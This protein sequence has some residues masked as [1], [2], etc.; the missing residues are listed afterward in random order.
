MNVYQ[1]QKGDQERQVNWK[2]LSEAEVKELSVWVA[3][4]LNDFNH[5]QLGYQVKHVV[6]DLSLRYA[7]DVADRYY[8]KI[9][10]KDSPHDSVALE[11]AA[12]AI[13]GVSAVAESLAVG[14]LPNNDGTISMDEL[15]KAIYEAMVMMLFD[16]KPS[17][18][19][20][21]NH[22]TL[23]FAERVK[24][25]EFRIGVAV[26]RFGL[27][28]LESFMP[29]QGNL[30]EQFVTSNP[31]IDNLQ[32]EIAKVKQQ[33]AENDQLVKDLKQQQKVAQQASDTV[34]QALKDKQNEFI[35]A[36]ENVAQQQEKLAKL[37]NTLAT[38]N[39]SLE[40]K[41]AAV[42]SAN[43]EVER[44]NQEVSEK[45]KVLAEIK[46][47]EGQLKAQRADIERNFD[48]A[49]KTLEVK[50]NAVDEAKGHL[51]QHHA[52]LTKRQSAVQDAKGQLAQAEDNL[53]HS[54]EIKAVSEEKL[55]QV[56]GQVAATSEA[57]NTALSELA[58]VQADFEQKNTSYQKAQSDYAQKA[59]AV[60]QSKA[61]VADLEEKLANY[62][63]ADEL[64]AQAKD[65]Y[66]HALI[67]LEQAKAELEAATNK[68]ND[69]KVAYEKQSAEVSRLQEQLAE[70]IRQE[71]YNQAIDE[72]D[73]KDDHQTN[74]NQSKDNQKSDS[75]KQNHTQTTVQ[76]KST[77][78]KNNRL[79]SSKTSD[80]LPKTGMLSVI[81]SVFGTMILGFGF[82][83]GLGNHRRM[84]KSKK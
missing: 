21:T 78:T 67:S 1:S 72:V 28:H 27:I 49:Q 2:N 59:K 71:E 76:S 17:G 38:T 32:Q 60:E 61:D 34:Q 24:V 41:L 25:K 18:W 55:A 80:K 74:E 56:E 58:S 79:V 50:Q 84:K 10:P 66:V 20:H 43:A 46:A 9:S 40:E 22:L 83:L 12:Q 26:D 19:T 51:A 35:Q 75:Q 3:D 44:A 15:K 53:A 8:Q 7:Q 45:Q 69:A 62:L 30:N 37:Q 63:N 5:N 31:A 48:K 4:V 42:K 73:Q 11:E 14:F 6:S 52:E 33:L 47:S 36:K 29:K 81:P 13:G 82:I 70:I 65:R 23:T 77:K 57:L 39:G 64:L 68:V 16:D 54:E